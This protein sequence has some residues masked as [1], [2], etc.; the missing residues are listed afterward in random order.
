LNIAVKPVI[1]STKDIGFGNIIYSVHTK[2]KT[3][4]KEYWHINKE[5]IVIAKRD[6]KNVKLRK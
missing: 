5:Y 2:C 6:E 3:P 1:N 4:H